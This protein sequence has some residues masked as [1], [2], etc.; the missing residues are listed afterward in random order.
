MPN[1]RV[2]V[3]PSRHMHPGSMT[4][5]EQGWVEIFPTPVDAFEVYVDLAGGKQQLG[6]INL[7]PGQNEGEVVLRIQ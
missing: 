4:T 6:P 1:V 5:D 2:A 3:V 7:A